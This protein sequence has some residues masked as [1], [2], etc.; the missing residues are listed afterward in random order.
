MSRLVRVAMLKVAIPFACVSGVISSSL[1]TVVPGPEKLWPH[2]M[3]SD[4]MHMVKY[5]IRACAGHDVLSGRSGFCSWLCIT[6]REE[7][8]HLQER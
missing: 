3:S 6:A 8:I 5:T 7:A 1:R 2:G 4:T